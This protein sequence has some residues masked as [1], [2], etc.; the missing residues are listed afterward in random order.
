MRRKQK[1]LK[2]AMS[3]WDII[4]IFHTEII[5]FYFCLLQGT[6][7]K[8]RNFHTQKNYCYSTILQVKIGLVPFM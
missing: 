2:L 7:I 5:K 8:E 1:Q 3:E 6:S 4:F